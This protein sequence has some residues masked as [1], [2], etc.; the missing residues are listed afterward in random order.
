M[1]W[2]RDVTTRL[3]VLLA[4]VAGAVLG[5]TLPAS[6]GVGVALVAAA[7]ATL[8]VLSARQVYVVGQLR[9]V[10]AVPATGPA[11]V[12]AGRVTDPVHHPLRPRAPGLA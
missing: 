1:T 2:A 6:P 8:L 4:A 7:L 3:L 11:P 12:L 5:S 10:A 9:P